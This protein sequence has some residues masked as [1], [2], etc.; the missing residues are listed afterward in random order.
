MPASPFQ[1][2][3]QNPDVNDATINADLTVGSAVPYILTARE[4]E[5]I[6]GASTVTTAT[7]P[8]GQERD[9]NGADVFISPSP[10]VPINRVQKP[11]PPRPSRTPIACEN[12]RYVVNSDH[13]LDFK[14]YVDTEDVSRRSR[15]KCTGEEP[16]CKS[17]FQ[18][19]KQCGG[20]NIPRKKP[21]ASGSRRRED[22]E[23]GNDVST[24]STEQSPNDYSM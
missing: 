6:A 2:N 4:A 11:P 15:V 19:E 23:K 22:V 24:T 1:Q 17:C 8:R 20:Y 14:K 7:G 13:M 5:S 18:Q 16:S 10:K 12:C 3:R 9:A 21:A